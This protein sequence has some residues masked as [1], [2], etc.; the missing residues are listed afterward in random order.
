MCYDD[1]RAFAVI[2]IRNQGL[3]VWDL[4]SGSSHLIQARPDETAYAL[5]CYLMDDMLAAVTVNQDGVLRT[6][7]LQHPREGENSAADP[8]VQ[9]VAW[10]ASA[11]ESLLVTGHVDGSLTA[12]SG[13][14]HE[15]RYRIPGATGAITHLA[16][17]MAQQGSVIL[18]GS[19]DGSGWLWCDDLTAE[20]RRLGPVAKPVTAV[21]VADTSAGLLAFVADGQGTVRS[22]DVASGAEGVPMGPHD[23]G[24]QA[25]TLL[26]VDRGP[27]LATADGNAGMR[28]WDLSGE[29]V[30]MPGSEWVNVI[31]GGSIDGQRWLVSGDADGVVRLWDPDHY[32]CIAEL[33]D[34]HDSPITH[35]SFAGLPG[36]PVAVTG[37]RLGRVQFWD[38]ARRQP[39]V[40]IWLPADCS[41]LA[42]SAAGALAIV[43]EGEV[44]VLRR[45]AQ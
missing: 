41:G 27:R 14:T 24:V 12:W 25:L 9:M 35:L 31:A 43:C 32:I 1:T 37:D 21:T 3:R 16:A 42:L 18:G 2:A 29:V 20:P 15:G 23:N 38:L 33:P 5:T 4:R 34:P 40:T 17:T 22:W 36:G 44:F 7:N 8:G 19:A 39:V 30:A 13:N 11:S 10:A 6:W 45:S 28:V 26:D